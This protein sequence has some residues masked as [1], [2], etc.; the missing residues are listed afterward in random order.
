MFGAY[1]ITCPE[2]GCKPGFRCFKD[3]VEWPFYRDLHPARFTIWNGF[4]ELQKLVARAKWEQSFNVQE[5]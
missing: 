2:C 5:E 1:L 4:S 3:G